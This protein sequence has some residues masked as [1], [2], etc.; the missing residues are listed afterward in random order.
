M[1]PIKTFLI[2]CGAAV[3]F[4]ALLSVT[5]F[6]FYK[7]YAD[8]LAQLSFKIS[9]YWVKK[10]QFTYALFW[11]EQSFRLKPTY[12]PVLYKMGMI[13][14]EL[15]H[16]GQ[17]LDYF[18]LAQLQNPDNVTYAYN[19]G[20]AEYELGHYEVAI[21]HWFNA[22]QNSDTADIDIYYCMGAAYEALNDWPAAIE[23][24]RQALDVTP[25]H[26]EILYALASS[27]LEAGELDEALTYTMQYIEMYENAEGYNLL[28]LIHV[29]NGN[30]EQA[31]EAVQCALALEPHNAEALNN[32]AVLQT[33]QLYSSLENSIEMLKQVKQTEESVQV[34]SQYNLM[35]MQ[36]LNNN[37]LDASLTL[38]ELLK[39]QP[40]DE[41]IQPSVAKAKMIIRYKLAETQM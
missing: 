41:R 34:F 40:L 28:V 25:N 12:P 9:S 19:I 4:L 18:Y 39:Q 37:Y 35:V 8:K 30:I 2:L 10:Q 29:E 15:G 36:G 11:M 32:F 31:L 27:L 23:I 21:S 17:A 24:Y 16:H 26:Q 14:Q 33:Q 6:L 1:E 20:V 38:N 3:V 22:L 5:G 7:F 13:H